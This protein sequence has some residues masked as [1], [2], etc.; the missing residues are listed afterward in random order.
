MLELFS[1]WAKQLETYAIGV[2][3]KGLVVMIAFG[4]AWL[5]ALGLL[6]YGLYKL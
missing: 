4:V 6:I 1:R 2:K 5:C 3:N